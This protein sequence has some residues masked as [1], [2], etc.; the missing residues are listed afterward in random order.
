MMKLAP[1][2]KLKLKF[3]SNVI[4]KIIKYFVIIVYIDLDIM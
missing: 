1:K 2:I 3:E 4:K